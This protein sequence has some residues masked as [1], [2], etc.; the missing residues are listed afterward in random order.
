LVKAFQAEHLPEWNA[1]PATAVI[2]LIALR[3]MVAVN[4]SAS[5]RTF[6]PRRFDFSILF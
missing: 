4:R 2:V 3:A 5:A 1:N 6:K